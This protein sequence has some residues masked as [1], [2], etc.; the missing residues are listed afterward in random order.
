VTLLEIE[1]QIP[2]PWILISPTPWE[3]IV[4]GVASVVVGIF[5]LRHENDPNAR[6]GC[7][8]ALAAVLLIAW[9][10]IS[11]WVGLAGLN[12]QEA[13]PGAAAQKAYTKG[14]DFALAVEKFDKWA[15]RF[16]NILFLIALVFVTVREL[17]KPS[18]NRNWDLIAGAIILLILGVL[19]L[20]FGGAI[21]VRV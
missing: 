14:V 7:N 1:I 8:Q 5:V 13:D 3:L 15:T 6:G 9:G 12:A 17:S 11:S 4:C 16:F 2:T 20:V 21:M 19:V 10:V 18:E